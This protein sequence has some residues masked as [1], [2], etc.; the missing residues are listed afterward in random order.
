M[1]QYFLNQNPALLEGWGYFL[2]E[3]AP[4]RVARGA[5]VWC[6]SRTPEPSIDTLGVEVLDSGWASNATCVQ[7]P[8]APPPA[9]SR[10][11]VMGK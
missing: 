6:P 3:E 2:N 11:V 10:V 7:R 8:P 1:R 9:P 5:L 4:V